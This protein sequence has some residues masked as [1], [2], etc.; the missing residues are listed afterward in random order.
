MS[1]KT[2]VRDPSWKNVYNVFKYAWPWYSLSTGKV[3]SI[4][5]K[6]PWLCFSAIDHISK[7]IR[8]DMNVFEYGSGGSTLFWASRVKQVVSVEHDEKWQ[9]QMQ[10]E[11]IKQDAANVKYILAPAEPDES[12][13]RKSAGDP[14]SYISGDPGYVGKKFEAYVKQIDIYPNQYFDFIIIDGRARPS[15]VLHSL[16]KLTLNGFVVLDN[17]ER[18]Y[19]RKAINLMNNQKWKMWKFSGPVPYSPSFSETTVFQK[20]EL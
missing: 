13:E 8:P 19:Y 17:T 6:I 5:T 11:F 16:A 14:Y 15:C 3:S 4:E 12:Y 1:V 18:D 10:H 9:S 7:F 20:I 2:V